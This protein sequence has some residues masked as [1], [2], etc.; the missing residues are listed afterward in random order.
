MP[1]ITLSEAIAALKQ[2][3]QDPETI[4]REIAILEAENT[5]DRATIAGRVNLIR[6]LRRLGGI[7]RKSPA[8]ADTSTTGGEK[9]A[10]DKPSDL[11]GKI[12]DYLTANGP[13]RATEIG[14]DIGMA[15][16]PL[17]ACLN[18][19]IGKYWAKQPD[20]RWQLLGK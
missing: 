6:T 17:V 8:T 9:P 14:R 13:T 16:G 4:T 2:A 12:L 11:S 19:G 18:R 1:A 20:G 7:K 3:K 15:I 10:D 5:K